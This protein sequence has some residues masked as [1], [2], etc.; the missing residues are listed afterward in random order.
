[1]QF[2]VATFTSLLLGTCISLVSAA[3]TPGS[4]APRSCTKIYPSLVTYIDNSSPNLAV[5]ALGYVSS[6]ATPGANGP[7]RA[8]EVQFTLPSA[9]V[10]GP[11]SLLYNFPTG[12]T[13]TSSG[14]S[15]AQIRVYKTKLGSSNSINFQATDTWNNSPDASFLW[16][17][18]NLVAGTSGT[19]NEETCQTTLSYFVQVFDVWAELSGT[20]PAA[21]ASFT[22]STSQGLY[23]TFG[24]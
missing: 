15:N 16:G 9:N 11:C 18:F 4:L 6:Y 1:M 3:P 2:S 22:Q 13:I 10:G 12:A 20:T 24:C 7:W 23:M 14:G 5:G 19:I 17:S 8:A 21:S